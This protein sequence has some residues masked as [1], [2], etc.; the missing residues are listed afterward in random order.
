MTPSRILAAFAPSRIFPDA[1]WW[2]KFL[3]IADAGKAGL[4]HTEAVGKPCA[5]WLKQGY[6]VKSIRPVAKGRPR[7]FYVL[8][9]KGEEYVAGLK[10][11]RTDNV[12]E[13]LP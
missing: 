9:P 5:R 3:R 4:P 2:I 6:V 8:G 7:V 13:K 11:P 10:S 1:N 12:K